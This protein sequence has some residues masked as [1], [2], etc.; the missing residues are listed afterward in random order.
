MIGADR[1]V[2]VL[3]EGLDDLVKNGLHALAQHDLVAVVELQALPGGEGPAVDGGAVDGL[4]VLQIPGVPLSRQLG[5]S[6]ADAVQALLR[7]FL[8]LDIAQLAASEQQLFSGQADRFAR[9]IKNKLCFQ[10]F[11]LLPVSFSGLMPP[12]AET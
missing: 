8:Y 11:L 3:R 2:V 10:C 6:A 1:F 4:Q 5:V 12:R 7:L 9:I